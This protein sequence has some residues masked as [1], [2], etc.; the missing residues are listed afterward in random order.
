MIMQPE[1]IQVLS[2]LAA[3]VAGS[4][5]GLGFGAIQEAAARRYERLQNSGQLTSGWALTPG[6]MSRT[7]YLL[8]ALAAVQ[9]LCPL[10]FKDG[11]Q[12]WVSGGVVAGYGWSLWR[13]LRRSMAT[14]GTR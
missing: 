2:D 3:L 6:S 14:R 12:W 5:I 13:K 9:F 4:L 7:A 8:V 11:C 1:V 10:L